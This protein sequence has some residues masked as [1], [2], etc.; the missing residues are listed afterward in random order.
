MRL[1]AISLRGMYFDRITSPEWSEQL[2]PQA[3][4]PIISNHIKIQLAL[5]TFELPKHIST[6]D[7]PSK[8]TT[9][10]APLHNRQNEPNLPAFYSYTDRYTEISCPN[11][12]QSGPVLSM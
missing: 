1:R 11:R 9:Q 4:P 6:I 10:W 7:H 8:V 5:R 12:E 2:L 3:L